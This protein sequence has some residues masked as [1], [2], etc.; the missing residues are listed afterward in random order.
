MR[1]DVE[2]EIHQL[3]GRIENLPEV[4]V[5]KTRGYIVT[6]RRGTDR[7]AKGQRTG[8]QQNAYPPSK[9]RV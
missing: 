3:D 2:I 9:A 5:F 7:G 8:G 6:F 4:K 1:P